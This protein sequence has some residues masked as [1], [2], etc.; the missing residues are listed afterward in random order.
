M[1]SVNYNTPLAKYYGLNT[2][3]K[4]INAVI[5]AS[6]L[7]T[8]TGNMFEWDGDTWQLIE[9]E[10][11]IWL[12]NT[13]TTLTGVFTV[14]E[15]YGDCTFTTLTSNATVNGIVIPLAISDIGTLSD[16]KRLY[17][18]FTSIRLNSG[19]CICYR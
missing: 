8:N 7:E 10:S 11:P 15:A 3:V 14:I 13:T 12:T 2:D 4:P 5:G 9:K 17:G 16:G 6:F 19:K 18:V 1:I